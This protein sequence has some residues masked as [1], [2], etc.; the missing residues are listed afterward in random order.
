MLFELS[1]LDS[2]DDDSLLAELGRVAGVVDAPVLTKSAF[3]RHS[4]ASAS[5]HQQALWWMG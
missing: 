5:V 2:Y 3:D 4:K 1:R